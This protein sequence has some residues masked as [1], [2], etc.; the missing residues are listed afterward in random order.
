MTRPADYKRFW[1]PSRPSGCERPLVVRHRRRARPLANSA[2]RCSR[3]RSTSSV[4][5]RVAPL[6]RA[7]IVAEV[8]IRTEDVL[9]VNVALLAPAGMKTLAGTLAAP[10]LLERVT[11]TP[12]AAAGALNVTVPLEDC[13]PPTTLVGLS[14]SEVRVGAGGGTGLTVKEADLVT[15][16]YVAK[17]VTAAD[18]VTPLVLTVNVALVAPAAT[19]T[20]AGTLATV[21]LLVESATC[22]PPA[23]A[24]PLSV[25]V[26]VDEFPPAT[27]VGFSVSDERENEAVLLGTSS[28]SRIAGF[29]SFRE[30]ATNFEG[31]II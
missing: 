20:V 19:A 15:T 24:G 21:V 22:A 14:V 17:M 12:P 27:L 1:N 2:R 9:T 6:Y 30:I 31:E 28:N 4:A 7:E 23:G 5:V 16:L 8:E 29:G 10:L 11:C 25:T 13:Q 18:A 3:Y 26:P